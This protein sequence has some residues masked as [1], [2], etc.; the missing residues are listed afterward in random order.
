MIFGNG[1]LD[2]YTGQ[3]G[4]VAFRL[5]ADIIPFQKLRSFRLRLDARFEGEQIT[6]QMSSIAEPDGDDPLAVA[7]ATLR[8]RHAKREGYC[9]LKAS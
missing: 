6:H 3:V 1:F 2:S 4:E 8:R 5:E 7:A 9:L